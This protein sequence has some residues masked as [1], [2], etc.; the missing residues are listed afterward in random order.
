VLLQALLG[1]HILAGLT[2]VVSGLV[3]MRSPKRAGSHPRLGRVYLWAMAVVFVTAS[4][5]SVA[6]WSDYA[7]LFV[8]G[9]LAFAAAALGYAAKRRR[10]KGWAMIHIPSMAVSY[11]V[12][13]TAFYVDN[14]PRLPIWNLLP[15]IAFWLLPSAIGLPLT[16][17][18]LVRWRSGRA[19]KLYRK[20]S[21]RQ[22]G[23]PRLVHRFSRGGRLP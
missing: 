22:G 18:A 1:V 2:C 14:G 6:R 11:I 15:P 5:I 12:L 16:S 13:L 4:A 21:A 8:L 7:Y 17:R 9:S 23:R 20:G 19:P 3:A 10:W